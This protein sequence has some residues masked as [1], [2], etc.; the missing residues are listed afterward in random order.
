M[1]AVENLSGRGVGGEAFWFAGISPVGSRWP[2]CGVRVVY[3]SAEGVSG[4]VAYERRRSP[5]G[6]FTERTWDCASG[7][8]MGL[9]ALGMVSG[10]KE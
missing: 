6:V 1:V 8:Y 10:Q 5:I 3:L 2:I 4:G 9:D 7:L